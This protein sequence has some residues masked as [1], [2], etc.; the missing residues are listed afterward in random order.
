MSKSK[1]SRREAVSDIL[2]VAGG[3]AV[4]FGVSMLHV[5]AGIIVGGAL[6]MAFG[7]LI[8]REV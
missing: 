4:S 5:A 6:A 8:G 1:Y 7:W 3:I 2:L